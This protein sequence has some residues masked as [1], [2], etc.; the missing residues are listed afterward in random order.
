MSIVNLLISTFIFSANIQK[1]AFLQSIPS[2][3]S[4][5]LISEKT[6]LDHLYPFHS[7]YYQ[8]LIT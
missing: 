1:K 2:N 7:E 4:I 8:H 3:F 5:F 6:I